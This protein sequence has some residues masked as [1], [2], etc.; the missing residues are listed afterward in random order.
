MTETRYAKVARDLVQGIGDGRFSVGSTLPTE[1]ELCEQ[2]GASRHTIRA[3]IREL[4][5]LGMVSRRKKAGTRVESTS[6]PSR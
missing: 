3:A 5:E 1:L 2:Y 4:Q 6:A